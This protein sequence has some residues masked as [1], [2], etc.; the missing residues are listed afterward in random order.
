MFSFE[1]PN[2]SSDFYDPLFPNA[3]L[4][5]LSGPVIGTVIFLFWYLICSIGD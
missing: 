4:V 3:R 5:S 2:N 1:N